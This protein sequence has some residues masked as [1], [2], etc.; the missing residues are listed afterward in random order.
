MQAGGMERVMGELANLFSNKSNIE[1]H[2]ILYGIKR[3]IFYPIPASVIVHRPLFI[4]DDSWRMISTFRTLFFL[5]RKVKNIRPD[6]M[7]SFGEYWNSFVLLAL[8]GLKFPLFVSDRS[9]P[10]KSLGIMHEKLRQWLYPKATGVIAQTAVAKN[11]YLT[12]YRHQNIRVIGNPIRNILDKDQ[13]SRENVVLTV[14]RLI[15]SKQQDKLIEIFAKINRPDW[16]LVIVGYDH[17]KQE[18]RHKLEDLAQKL[19]IEKSVLFVGKQ[20][21]VD[22]FYLSSKIFAF[23]SISEGFPNAIG[24]AMSAGLPVVAFDCVAGPS[25]MIEEGQNGFLIPLLD[26]DLFRMKLELLMEEVVL[27]ERL[28]AYARESISRFSKENIGEQFFQF[29]MPDK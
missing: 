22:D 23:T 7:L 20:S 28:G 21:N 18:N 1:V 14:G 4:F 11:V 29:I 8:Y 19:N 2:L 6:A 17:L 10:D 16:K 25:E 9:Q 12:K 24:E 26:L 13:I 5:R 3:D 27:R 15:E